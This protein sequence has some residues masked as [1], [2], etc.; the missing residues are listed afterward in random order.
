MAEGVEARLP[1]KLPES[2]SMRP[3]VR[4]HEGVFLGLHEANRVAK[5]SMTVKQQQERNHQV[6]SKKICHQP[7]FV[8]LLLLQGLHF[9]VEGKE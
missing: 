8:A 5:P 7:S 9:A 2:Y 3:A 4:R 6:C 1:K